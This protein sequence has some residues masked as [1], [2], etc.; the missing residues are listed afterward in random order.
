MLPIVL[1]SMLRDSK[2]LKNLFAGITIRKND[3]REKINSMKKH[4]ALNIRKFQKF[5]DLDLTIY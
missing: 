3:A 2:Q 4:Y 5:R 1:T